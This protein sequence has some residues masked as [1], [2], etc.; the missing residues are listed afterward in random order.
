M[1]AVGILA[2]LIT[3]RAMTRGQG[4]AKRYSVKERIEPAQVTAPR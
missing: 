2:E 4:A 1:L 3:A